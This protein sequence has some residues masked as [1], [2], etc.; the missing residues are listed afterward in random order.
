ML[1]EPWHRVLDSNT[2][3]LRR[4]WSVAG[5]GPEAAVIHRCKCVAHEQGERQVLGANVSM[6]YHAH[7]GL[8]AV[9]HPRIP[10]QD[11]GRPHTAP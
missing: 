4:V 2:I 5:L 1:N 11:T 10:K 9:Q 3:D 6:F 8:L 7:E